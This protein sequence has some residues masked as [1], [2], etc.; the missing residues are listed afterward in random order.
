MRQDGVLVTDEDK[1]TS[2][3]DASNASSP[4]VYQNFVHFFNAE[5][6]KA[7][8]SQTLTTEQG[9]TGSY[10]MSQTH[11]EVRQDVVDS[12]KRMV[13]FWLN[14]LI[15]WIVKF[16]FG[17]L[18]EMPKFEMYQEE[19]VDKPLAEVVSMLTQYKQVEF[20]K[21]FYK[22]RF[23]FA[24]DEINIIP[25]PTV[26]PSAPFAEPEHSDFSPTDKLKKVGY[27][28]FVNH[29]QEFLQPVLDLINSGMEYDEI[30]SKAIELYPQLDTSGIENV[31]ANSLVLASTGGY[32]S[33]LN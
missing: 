26:Q 25:T 1:K 30:Q 3:L 6:S 8:L 16:N 10:A 33:A 19:D 20:T 13:E 11:L 24:D 7:L 12:D 23:G 21:E 31:L 22:R 29:S 9:D 5:I 27:N 32:I 17:N 2:L 15:E 4:A 14:K 28:D 18:A